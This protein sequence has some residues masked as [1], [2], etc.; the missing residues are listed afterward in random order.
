MRDGAIRHLLN[1][2]DTE[3]VIS[4]ILARRF[5]GWLNERD[6]MSAKEKRMTVEQFVNDLTLEQVVRAKKNMHPDLPTLAEFRTHHDRVIEAPGSA[7]VGPLLVID[8][9]GLSLTVIS[10]VS[11]S[12][13]LPVSTTVKRRTTS[14]RLPGAV[15]V[16][17]ARVLAF[18]VTGGPL[19]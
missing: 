2:P 17:W 1:I 16:G 9:I 6:W 5:H 12:L 10:V 11:K 4:N 18:K 13:R 19:S 14:P 3:L 15:K 7:V 8:R